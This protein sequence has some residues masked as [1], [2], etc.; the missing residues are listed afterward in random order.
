MA[1]IKADYTKHYIYIC[2]KVDGVKKVGILLYDPE[3]TKAFT[4]I[5]KADRFLLENDGYILTR[6]PCSAETWNEVKK[7]EDNDDR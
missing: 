2:Y 7:K 6:E 5:N 4:D 3:T 1:K